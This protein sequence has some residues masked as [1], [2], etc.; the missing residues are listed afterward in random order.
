MKRS[1]ILELFPDATE[2]QVK[3]IMDLN[4]ADINKARGNFD[5]LKEQ[6]AA[7]TSELTRIQQEAPEDRLKE[8]I[9]K[10]NGLQAELD[11]FKRTDAIRQM[12][13]KVSKETKVP[14]D[15]LTAETEEA[16][17]DQAKAI[18]DFAQATGYPAIRDGG[19]AMIR[20]SSGTATRDKFADWAK[21]NL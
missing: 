20:V 6:L 12:R 13:E 21:E 15:L 18:L 9:A 17:A 2:E 1:D 8:A 4:G 11:G 10:A 14:I 3:K 5:E 19:E 7:A 16:C